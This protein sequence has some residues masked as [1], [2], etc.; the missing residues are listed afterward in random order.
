MSDKYG[1]SDKM[2]DIIMAAFAKDYITTSKVTSEFS[3]DE[4][5]ARRYLVRLVDY[6]YLV[7]EG[8][9]NNKK[10]YGLLDVLR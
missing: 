1:L 3:L 7:S 2:S 8:E 4:R 10:F 5:T 6:G 9:N